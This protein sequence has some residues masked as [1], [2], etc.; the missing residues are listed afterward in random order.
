[1]SRMKG[2]G[3]PIQACISRCLGKWATRHR[4][5]EWREAGPL[6][7][8]TQM[9]QGFHKQGI[10][11]K[12]SFC[13]NRKTCL[14]QQ[15]LLH[16]QINPPGSRKWNKQAIWAKLRTQTTGYSIGKKAI[17]IK[18]LTHD[19]CRYKK[20]HVLKILLNSWT[21]TV[22]GYHPQFKG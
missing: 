21:E 22:V 1:M 13:F 6:L 17:F 5:Q 4:E 16:M 7:I 15:N 10:W 2:P 8:T 18:G 12:M 19:S 11:Q 14:G 20:E 3:E 9:Q